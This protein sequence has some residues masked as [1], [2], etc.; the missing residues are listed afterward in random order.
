MRHEAAASPFAWQNNKAILSLSFSCDSVEMK[1]TS[2]RED[3]GSTPGLAQWVKVR[4]RHCHKIRI[5]AGWVQLRSS[6]AMAVA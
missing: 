4:I 1:L 6:L 2:I 3:A 5:G